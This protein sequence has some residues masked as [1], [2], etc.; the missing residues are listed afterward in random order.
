MESKGPYYYVNTVIKPN[1]V[2][3]VFTAYLMQ[4]PLYSQAKGRLNKK[5]VGLQKIGVDA[6]MEDQSDQGG[7]QVK[8][9]IKPYNEKGYEKNLVIVKPFSIEVYS[10]DGTDFKPKHTF[11]VF[12]KIWN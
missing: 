7:I 9:E 5:T 8:T 2:I 6:E 11:E 3:N 4:S 12:A 1:G 10:L